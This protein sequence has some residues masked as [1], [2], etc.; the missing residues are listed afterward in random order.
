MRAPVRLQLSAG[1]KPA[2]TSLTLYATEV[3][4]FRSVT[5]VPGLGDG[6]GR[7]VGGTASFEVWSY[8][9]ATTYDGL[10]FGGFTFTSLDVTVA[11]SSVASAGPSAPPVARSVRPASRSRPSQPYAAGS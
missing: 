1:S 3:E 4:T 8:A 10:G 7:V 5:L 2:E 6:L 11:P 9:T